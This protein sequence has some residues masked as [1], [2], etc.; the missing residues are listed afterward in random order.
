MAVDEAH[1]AFITQKVK[2]LAKRANLKSPE[3]DV[4]SI[5]FDGGRGLD[6]ILVIELSTCGFAE[7]GQ[8]VILQE[9]AGTGKAYLACTIAKEA[10]QKRMRSHYIRIPDLEEA[11]DLTRQRSGGEHKMLRNTLPLPYWS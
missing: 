1:S 3:A 4:K 8:N 2:N 10:C 9:L 7:R 6:R 11:W 5:D